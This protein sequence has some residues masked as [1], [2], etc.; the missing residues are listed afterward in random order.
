MVIKRTRSSFGYTKSK[1]ASAVS[2]IVP[3]TAG[4]A[5]LN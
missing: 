1:L 4:A 3:L 5:P 2:G